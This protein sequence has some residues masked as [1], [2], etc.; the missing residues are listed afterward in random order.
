MMAAHLFTSENIIFQRRLTQYQVIFDDIN[1][2]L[3]CT[4]AIYKVIWVFTFKMARSIIVVF[5]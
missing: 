4:V 3:I 1:L 2:S 5:N